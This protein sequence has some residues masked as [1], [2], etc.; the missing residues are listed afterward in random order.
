MGN[1]GYEE[2]TVQVYNAIPATSSTTSIGTTGGGN[3]GDNLQFSSPIML[4]SL[5]GIV[6]L[7]VVVGIVGRSRNSTTLSSKSGDLET[8][9]S[10]K[11]TSAPVTE[12]V[13]SER[14]LVICPFCGTKNE[15][16]KSNCQSCGAKL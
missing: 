9:G 10:E 1:S 7:I 14:F 6:G 5:L 2:I 12:K 16:G 3:T 4:A 8:V 15:Q 11:T 13:V